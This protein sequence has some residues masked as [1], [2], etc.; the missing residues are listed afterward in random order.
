[1]TPI[2]RML[3]ISSDVNR[4][5]DSRIGELAIGSASQKTFQG[6]RGVTAV[7]FGEPAH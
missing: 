7:S 3:S 2:Q 1:M 6:F 4:T 5:R